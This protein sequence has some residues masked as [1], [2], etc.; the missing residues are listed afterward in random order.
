[1]RDHDRRRIAL[2]DLIDERLSDAECLFDPDLHEGPTNTIELPAERDARET[3][4]KEVCASCPALDDCRIYTARTAPKSGIWAAM[5]PAERAA[6]YDMPDGSPL[7][8]RA[9]A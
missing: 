9:V 4:A 1:V 8:G 7:G 5:T 2:A 3:V 6:R